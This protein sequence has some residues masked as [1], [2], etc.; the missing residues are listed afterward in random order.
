MNAVCPALEWFPTQRVMW[1]LAPRERIYKPDELNL[2]SNELLQPAVEQ[3]VRERL[4][5]LSASDVVAYPLCQAARGAV[6]RHFGRR[7]DEV[8]LTPGTDHAIRVVSEALC[9]PAGRLVVADPHFES[10]SRYAVQYGFRVDAVEMPCRAPMDVAALVDRLRGGGQAVVVLTQP[11]G[12]TGQLY[13]RDEVEYLAGAAEAHGSL[14]VLDTCYLAFAEHGADTVATVGSRRN[15]LRVNS[16]SKSLGLAG[17]RVGAVLGDP[18]MVDYL[19]RWCADG[20]ITGLSLRLLMMALDDLGVFGAAW[21]EVRAAR[22]ALG[23]GL[24]DALPG[25]VARPSG[26]NF[27]AFDAS[28][29]SAVDVHAALLSDGIRTK[30]L[31]GLPGFPGG[32]RISTPSATA[33]DRVLAAALTG[34]R[35]SE[36]VT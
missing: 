31:S 7:P 13:R 4:W 20:M 9:A 35:R 33:A 24:A 17:A 30:L 12:I 14:L 2:K 27:V 15:V 29:E 3:W 11:D 25:W 23:R 8:L 5:A 22:A 1:E 26:A 28:P 36:A 10:W 34:A 18:S 21:A 32:I 6:A 19:S 16:F